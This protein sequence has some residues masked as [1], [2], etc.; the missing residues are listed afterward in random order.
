MS[1]FIW[2][3]SRSKDLLYSFQAIAAGYLTPVS[4]RRCAEFLTR[5]MKRKYNLLDGA[6]KRKEKDVIGSCNQCFN[7]LR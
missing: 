6:S 2:V 4:M 3:N 5:S 1:R 7:P